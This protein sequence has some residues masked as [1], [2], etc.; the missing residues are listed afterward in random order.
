[1]HNTIQCSVTGKGGDECKMTQEG[2]AGGRASVGHAT[3]VS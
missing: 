1:M 2:V 3:V